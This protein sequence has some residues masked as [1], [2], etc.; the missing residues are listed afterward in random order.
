MLGDAV[1]R[2]ERLDHAGRGVTGD[3]SIEDGDSVVH[4]VDAELAMAER[5]TVVRGPLRRRDSECGAICREL[6]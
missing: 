4:G 1:A 2:P 5:T 6:T 3:T